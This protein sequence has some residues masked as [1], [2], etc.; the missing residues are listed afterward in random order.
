MESFQSKFV[1][2][3]LRMIRLNKMWKLTGDDLRKRIEKKQLSDSCEPPK[4]MKKRFNISEN[5]VNGHY[6]YVIKPLD[7]IGN[8]H[9]L[10]LHGG[11]YVYTIMSLHW[12]F[13]S[14]LV[15]ALQCTITVPIYPLAPKYQYQDVFDMMVPIYQQMISEVK[16]EDVVFMGDSA[17]G[18]ISFALA[19]L[20]KE[21]NLS[22]PGNIILISPALD[23]SFS[24]PE[25][26]AVE[27]YD[28]IAA[29]P[30]LF[31]IGKWYGGGNGSKHY[32]VSPIYGSFDGLGNISLFTGTHD[33]TNPDARKF[34]AMA[35]EQ[36]ININYYEYPSMLHVWPLF[37]FPESKKATGQMIQIIKGMKV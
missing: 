5:E 3:L 7:G 29:V 8:K 9:I 11:G 23:L 15:D 34:K 4:Q 2:V 35:D 1:K 13:L 14:R 21:K 30:A 10:Y 18:G 12:D 37:S 24:N 17:G 28:P 6:Y 31:D 22:Q 33:I 36:G 19:Q 16:P 32:L 20:L 25:I 26:Q 27:K